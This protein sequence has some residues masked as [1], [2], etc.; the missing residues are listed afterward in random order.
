MG[1]DYEMKGEEYEEGKELKKWVNMYRNMVRNEELIRS[2]N[3]ERRIICSHQYDEGK[4][5]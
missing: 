2:G 3:K 1:A 5:E 4:V